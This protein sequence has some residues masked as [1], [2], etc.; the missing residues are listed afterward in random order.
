M[1]GAEMPMA[2]DQVVWAEQGRIHIAF[3]DV[4]LAAGGDAALNK[5]TFASSD[6]AAYINIG[7]T[8]VVSKGGKV[9]KCY[10]TGKSG[11]EVTA[12]PYKALS[13]IHI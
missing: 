6:D 3:N 7:D 8:I 1:V 12:T 11:A 10:V 2:S 5:L 13:L 9:A 4:S